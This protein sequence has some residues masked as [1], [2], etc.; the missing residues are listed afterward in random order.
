MWR[1]AICDAMVPL[2]SVVRTSRISNPYRFG[3]ALIRPFSCAMFATV[4]DSSD[5]VTSYAD[6][7]GR[8]T[9][10]I[11]VTKRADAST[12]T[13]VDLVKKNLP[14]FQSAV[15]DDVKVSYEFDHPLRHT[16]HLEF[17]PGRCAR[18][19]LSGLTVLLF[20]RDWRS[21]LVLY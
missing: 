17:D 9:V 11:P 12:L 14:K 16:R 10:Y 20:L 4:A 8:R 13:V 19:V 6:I 21:S 7:N 3:P 15:P 1:S 5:I 2:N 18:A